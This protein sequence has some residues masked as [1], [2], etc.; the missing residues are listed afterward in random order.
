MTAIT[1]PDHMGVSIDAAKNLGLPANQ[2]F[3]LR[4]WSVANFQ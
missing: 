1:L 4:L 2:E 3:Q